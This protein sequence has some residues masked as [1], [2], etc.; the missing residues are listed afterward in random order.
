MNGRPAE[1]KSALNSLILVRILAKAGK[2]PARAQIAKDLKPY[3]GPNQ[4]QSEWND[5]VED[6]LRESQ[7]AGLIDPKPFRLTDAGQTAA[8]A[9]LNQETLPGANWPTLRDRHLI[10]LALGIS[11]RDKSAFQA[12]GT[13]KGLRPAVL[14]KRFGLP[15]SRVPS[16]SRVVHLLAWQQLQRAHEIRVPPTEDF[17]PKAV[18]RATILKGQKGDPVTL[19][20]AQA[21]KADSNSL[22]HVREAVIRQWLEIDPAVPPDVAAPPESSVP[23]ER[24]LDLSDFASRVRELARTSPTGKFGENKVFLSHVWKRFQSEGGNG[25]TRADFERRLVDASRQNLLT[26]SRADLVSAMNPVDVADSEICLGNS[27]FH[28]I[29]TDR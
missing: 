5:S 21:T 28:F 7:A 3:V 22:R 25:M 10:A 18:L 29:R 20:A 1:P 12:V 11:A 23:K 16:E 24:E 4:S 15:G 13:S 17:K 2:P 6:A 27:T 14:V 9:F 19:L 26:L 8:L